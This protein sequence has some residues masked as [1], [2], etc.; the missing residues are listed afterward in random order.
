MLKKILTFIN[1]I[2][3]KTNYIIFNSYP[4]FS[5]NSKALYDYIQKSRPDIAENYKLI[6]AQKKAELLVNHEKNVVAVNKHSIKGIWIFLRSK[7]VF[8]THGYFPNVKSGAGQI[9]VNLWH[10]CGYKAMTSDDRC[11]RGDYTLATSDLYK[12]LQAEGL[13]MDLQNVY[14]TGY[15]RND[16]MF[17]KKGALEKLGISKNRYK[18]IYIWMPTYR[19][20]SEGHKGIDGDDNSFNISKI[21][22]EQYSR[23]N[24]ILKE[25][26]SLLIIKPHPMDASSVQIAEKLSRIAIIKNK[27]LDEKHVSLYDLLSETD[28]LMSDYSSVIVDYL[29]L[30]KPIIMVLSDMV[31]YRN[32]RG[33]VFEN[34]EMYFP[35]PIISN[36]EELI[37]YFKYSDK[38]DEKWKEKRI[39]LKK[40]FHKYSDG[41]SSERV[42][43]LF[44]GERNQL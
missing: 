8:S 20:A 30:D 24:N 15:P 4:A 10:G 41:K 44:F 22:S 1:R 5:D 23:L 28:C 38:I 12:K 39:E 31:E 19:K 27:D 9:Q 35:G 14:I 3:P 40:K 6:W 2:I 32:S 33:F 25:K 13:E 21:T 16:C 11:Y 17:S 18:K 34:V 36:I 43:D 37:A 29:L 26:G 7:Y 42:C